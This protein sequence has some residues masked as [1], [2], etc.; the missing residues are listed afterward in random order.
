MRNLINIQQIY[1]NHKITLYICAGDFNIDLLKYAKHTSTTEFIN[2][3]FSCNLF[4][5][6]SKPT[7]ITKTSATLIDNIYVTNNLTVTHADIL[8]ADI[9]KHFP[10]YAIF[11]LS[12]DT[13]R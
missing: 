1:V 8:Y 9:S 2:L 5:L 12:I 13:P 10:I 3:L 11:P 6:I 7:R 4:P